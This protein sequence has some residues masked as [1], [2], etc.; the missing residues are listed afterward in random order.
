MVFGWLVCVGEEWDIAPNAHADYACIYLYVNIYTYH[1]SLGVGLYYTY[2]YNL[3]VRRS[4]VVT[5]ATIDCEVRG[6]N[7]GLGRNLKTRFLLYSHPCGGEGMS[8]VQGETI[9]CCER[10]WVVPLEEALYK[11][12]QWMNEWIKN[13]NTYLSYPRDT[14]IVNK[15]GK[16]SNI[17]LVM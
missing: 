17:P 12:L 9:R 3:G 14:N 11:C 10:F 15:C 16:E 2:I 8:P 7:Q 13:L 5:F 6:S 4:R 1:C